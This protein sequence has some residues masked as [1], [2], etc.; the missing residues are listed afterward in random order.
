MM[1]FSKQ[2]NA[3]IENRLVNLSS[4]SQIWLLL[5]TNQTFLKSA[6]RVFEPYCRNSNLS[7]KPNHTGK[8]TRRRLRLV[9]RRLTLY[10]FTNNSMR[11]LYNLLWH[12]K[13]LCKDDLYI[14]IIMQ[15]FV[16]LIVKPFLSYFFISESI[17]STCLVSL[18]T[19]SSG[20]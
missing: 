9:D 7:F 20:V 10:I 8:T 14:K 4:T 6:N 18:F 2:L 5:P 19:T 13:I 12:K 16:S 3:I 1:R 15:Y 17:I 11:I